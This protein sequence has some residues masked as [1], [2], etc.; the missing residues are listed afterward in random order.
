MPADPDGSSQLLQAFTRY[1]RARPTEVGS[2]FEG[3]TRGSSELGGVPATTLEPQVG[4]PDR[5]VLYFHGGGYVSGSPPERYLPLAAAVAL[6]ANA[7]VHVVDYRLARETRF[8]CA[9]DDCLRAYSW[10]V[11]HGG[12]DAETFALLGDSVAAT[13]RSP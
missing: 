8:P 5:S 1:L 7:L 11:E 2:G 13:S 10:L 3:V 6:T 4:P 12:A 9:F